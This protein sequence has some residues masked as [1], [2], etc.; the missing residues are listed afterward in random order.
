MNNLSDVQPKSAEK[1][2]L[3]RSY[4]VGQELDWQASTVPVK[5]HVEL[6]YWLMVP[7]CIQHVEVNGHKFHVAIRDNYIELYFNAVGDSKSTCLYL[8]PPRRP[9]RD[10]EKAIKKSKVP[11]ISRKCKTV[12]L[13]DSECNRDV[14]VASRGKGRRKNPANLYLRSFCEAHLDIVN[15]LVQQYRLSTYDYFAYELSP[16][17][18]PT[19]FVVSGTDFVRI[20][21]QD[22][23]AWDEKPMIVDNVSGGKKE[24]YKLI[25]PSDL[26]AAL[27]IQP[28]A[29]EFELLDALNF[30]ERGD[31]SDAVRRIT[32][33]I[34]AQTEYAL[35]QELL[36]KLPL[37]DVEQTLEDTKTNFPKRFEL[38]QNSSG[39]KLNDAL[40]KELDTTRKLRHS[41]VH[42]GKRIA[43]NER[44][45]AQKSVDT[46]RWIFNWIENE[47][48]RSDLREKRIGM[49]SLGRLFPKYHAEITPTGVIVHKPPF[50]KDSS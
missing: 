32:T 35:R 33:A 13:I 7:D 44:G 29:G 10:V 16:W 17:D 24:R 15:R 2:S 26:Q 6:P 28:S 43:F 36:K 45:Q 11:I 40:T 41:I 14:L 38:Y 31:Y 23:A 50:A 34:E 1:I 42:S 39:R 19:W 4:W 48:A 20:V 25:D 21:L 27:A 9:R 8:G 3:P 46:G 5:L 47:P 49:R 30:M 12:L 37:P 18:I 22:Y